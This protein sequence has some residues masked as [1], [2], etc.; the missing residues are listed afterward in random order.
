[1]SDKILNLIL[2]KLDPLESE[3]KA[4]RKEFKT[5][6]ESIRNEL[7]TEIGTVKND[8]SEMRNEFQSE[9]KFIH[10]EMN[11]MRSDISDIKQSVY[12][13]EESQLKNIYA[14]L[15]NNTTMKV[16]SCYNHIGVLNKRLFKAESQIEELFKSY[17]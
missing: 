1:M 17:K 7:R 13:L 12:R 11:E 14:L 9:L 16:D 10:I 15:K 5:E 4:I 8:I 3:T 6:T 2:N